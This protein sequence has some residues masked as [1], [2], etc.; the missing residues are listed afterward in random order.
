MP[1]V[2][3]IFFLRG[4]KRE[5]KVL[6]KKCQKDGENWVK[7]YSE[8]LLNRVLFRYKKV[9]VTTPHLPTPS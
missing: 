3:V 2:Y 4:M 9:K 1:L 8:V 7:T 6:L 5:G